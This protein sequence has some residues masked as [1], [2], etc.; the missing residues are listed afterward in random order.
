ML[1]DQTMRFALGAVSLT[2]LVLFYL[3]VYRNTRS[4][5]SGWWCVSL[6]LAGLATM[7]LLFNES[8]VRVATYPVSTALAAAGAT[9]V[10]FAMRSL[11]SQKLP[12]WL[13]V[14][15]PVV[16]LV[17]A[18]MA[19]PDDSGM[20][21]TGPV[22]VYMAAMFIAGAVEAW[23]ARRARRGSGE[24]EANGEAQ[25]AL[26]VIALAATALS[27]FYALRAVLLV[28][29][30]PESAAFARTAGSAA[31]D[32]ALLVCMVAV[33]FS[34][35][36]VGWDQQ[37]QAL[38][39]RATQDDL[40]SLWGRSEFR[41]QAQRALS[42]AQARGDKALLVFADL[43]HF[44]NVNDTHGHAAG[45]GA[46]VEFAA[47]VRHALRSGDLAGRMGGEEFGLVLLDVDDAQAL[48]RL[49]GISEAFAARSKKLGFTLP[50]V[51]YGIA[52]REEGD[53]GAEVYER[54]DLALYRAKADGRDRAVRYTQELGWRANRSRGRRASDLD[55]EAHSEGAS[56]GT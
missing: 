33:T 7:L 20:A 3:G 14:V 37:T 30:G 21:T 56:A 25:V 44:K 1:D 13:L 9:C 23:R 12:L 8:P 31:E 19:P 17:P 24:P 28:L 41:A 10:W 45:D 32:V 39:R 35:S 46:L 16:I 26:L 15:G 2:V 50:T 55:P 18:S 43:D 40:T 42:A 6:L 49:K 4:S 29:A 48:E 27:T 38:R 51:S 36:A 11:R 34:V 47:V 52:G 5:F 22:S 54:A 53:V